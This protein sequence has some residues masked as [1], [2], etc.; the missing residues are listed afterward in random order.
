MSIAELRKLPASEKLEIIEQLWGEFASGQQD[1]PSPA[2]HRR[3]LEQTE[4]DFKSGDLK[5]MPWT[6]AKAELQRRFS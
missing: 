4:N 6:E 5:S 2:W 1:Y 3:A